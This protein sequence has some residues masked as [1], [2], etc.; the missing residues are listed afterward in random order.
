MA[1][2]PRNNT[3]AEQAKAAERRQAFQEAL[4]TA[5]AKSGLN[6]AQISRAM[7][8][9]SP[10]RD[11][12]VAPQTVRA[13]ETGYRTP[14]TPGKVALIEQVLASHVEP[15]ELQ[16]LLGFIPVEIESRSSSVTRVQTS[17]GQIGDLSARVAVSEQRIV[18]MRAAVAELAD[19]H[20][21]TQEMVRWIFDQ[22]RSATG[23]TTTPRTQL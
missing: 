4:S 16:R 20:R 21:E 9:R 10:H 22:M 8:A 17:R 2:R 23:S 6:P 13:W 18:E 7:N 14:T 1:G 5:I 15:G 11:F 12:E 19:D 3:D